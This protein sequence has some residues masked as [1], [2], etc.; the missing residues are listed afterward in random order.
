[1]KSRPANFALA[2]LTL[3]MVSLGLISSAWAQT[4]E[5]KLD[6]AQ[7]KITAVAAMRARRAPQVTAEEIMRLKL[8][9]VVS[10]IARSTNQDTIGGE[11]DYLGRV[12][13]PN[14]GA[15][16]VFCGPPLHLQV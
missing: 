11:S 15:G 5:I 12:K 4:D 13:L 6:S 3:V 1:M 10:A 14:S 7:S 16:V 9:T 2:V 8:G